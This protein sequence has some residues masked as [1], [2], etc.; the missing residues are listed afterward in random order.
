MKY[1]ILPLRIAFFW[2]F[3]ATMAISGTASISLVAYK[4]YVRQAANDDTYIITT[5]KQHTTTPHALPSNMLEELIGLSKDWPTYLTSFNTQA[6]LQRLKSS[7]FIKKADI[8]KISPNTIYV[9]Y[10]LRQPVASLAG[11]SHAAFDDDGV[12]YPLDFSQENTLLP[13]IVLDTTD[14]QINW[15][16]RL[17]SKN[18][19]QALAVLDLLKKGSQ[20]Q[21][22]TVERIDVSRIE[23]LSAGQREI[24]VVLNENGISDQPLKIFLRLSIEHYE[25][26][27]ENFWI[28]YRHEKS[29]KEE[30]AS[31]DTIVDLRV[32]Q[33]AFL[34]PVQ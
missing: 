16:Q 12:V 19:T 5:L 20:L 23:S 6:A 3:L 14:Q 15:G 8:K 32:P 2:I 7:P 10:V 9:D 4:W 31:T 24:L 22:L 29:M 11:Y 28:L 27:L 33:L 30:F 18:F 26:G 34:S 25:K 21:P 17:S 13:E 1:D